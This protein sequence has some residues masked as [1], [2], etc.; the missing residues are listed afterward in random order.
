[1]Y[2][3][4]S[5]GKD[6]KVINSFVYVGWQEPIFSDSELEVKQSAC[7]CLWLAYRKSLNKRPR[8]LFVQYIRTPSIY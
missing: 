1:M 6:V 5:R 7:V 3:E 2:V 4:I 8:R